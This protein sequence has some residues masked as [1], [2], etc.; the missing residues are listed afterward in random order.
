MASIFNIKQGDTRPLLKAVLED[1]NGDPL[2]VSGASGISFR[3]RKADGT[4]HSY[5]VSKA[6][7]LT[8]DGTDGAVE[9]T[10]TAVETNE[11]GEFYGEF[12][13]NWGSSNFQTMPS[14]GYITVFVRAL[15]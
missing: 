15:A 8:T 11:D 14:E 5:K 1:G 6:A 4:P 7:A 12:V 3:M 2:D 13:I 9:V 10:F